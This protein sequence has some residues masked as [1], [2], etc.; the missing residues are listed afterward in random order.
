LLGDVNATFGRG[1]GVDGPGDG[2]SEEVE[3]AGDGMERTSATGFG[4]KRARRSLLAMAGCVC[5]SGRGYA[6]SEGEWQNT[7]EVYWREGWGRMNE[8]EDEGKVK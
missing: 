6:K 3:D 2:A 8:G 1:G 5:G 4:L 7:L